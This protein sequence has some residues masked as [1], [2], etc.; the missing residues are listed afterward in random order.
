MHLTTFFTDYCRMRSHVSL[1][2]D[3]RGIIVMVFLNGVLVET[4]ISLVFRTVFT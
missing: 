3:K 2:G 4:P 1:L